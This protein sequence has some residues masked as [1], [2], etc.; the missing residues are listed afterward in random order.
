MCTLPYWLDI[1]DILK[2]IVIKRMGVTRE[3]KGSSTGIPL[4]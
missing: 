3:A 4:N 2:R 1:L